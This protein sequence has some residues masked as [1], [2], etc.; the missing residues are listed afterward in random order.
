M[1][2][3]SFYKLLILAAMVLAPML[4]NA[5]FGTGLV[6]GLLFGSSGNKTV[7]NAIPEAPYNERLYT[8]YKQNKDLIKS[9]GA[10]ASEE[11]IQRNA[12]IETELVKL[13][14]AE[15]IHQFNL[16]MP[17]VSKVEIETE[18]A[19]GLSNKMNHALG[20]GD[21]K[22]EYKSTRAHIVR[23]IEFSKE[24][25]QPIQDF[26]VSVNGSPVSPVNGRLLYEYDEQFGANAL[27]VEFK[28]KEHPKLSFALSE[29]FPVFK[30]ADKK[31]SAMEENY[32]SS[33]AKLAG[34]GLAGS[35]IVYL[36]LLTIN[37]KPS[38]A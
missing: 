12:Q 33:M 30:A 17:V 3:L 4:A 32:F 20:L 13:A 37:R 11:L 16:M 14:R 24:S 19:S 5:G 28:N 6:V 9:R 34:V 1:K 26:E 27:K 23:S 36:L 31:Q 8:E 21:G 29:S 10:A 2:T 7:V 35:V 38:E 22:S 25:P 18:T 15:Y